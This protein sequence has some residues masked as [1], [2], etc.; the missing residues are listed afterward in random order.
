MRKLVS[1]E[2]ALRAIEEA[3]PAQPVGVVELSLEEALWRVAAEDVVA[4]MDVPG[5]RRALMD[6]YAVRAEDTFGAELEGPVRLRLVGSVRMGEPAEVRIGPGECVEVATGAMM[7]E[8]AD[9]VV[10]VEATV[11]EGD[12]VLVFEP[13]AP[14]QNVMAVGADVRAGDVVLRAGELLTPAKLGVLSA[15]GLRSVRVFKRPRVAVISTGDEL[16]EPGRPLEP[17]KIYDINW[18][19]LTAAIRVAGGEPIFMGRAGDELDELTEL[20]SR[21]LE[22]ADM[23]VASGASSVGSA[24]IMRDAL[25]AVGARVIVDGIRCKPGKP[26]IVALRGRKPLFCLPGH[27]TSAL[28][29]FMVFAEPVLAKMA[30]LKGVR[31]PVAKAI[32]VSRVLPDTGRHNFVPVA[33]ERSPDGHLLAKPIAKGSGAITSLSSAHGLVEAPEGT[34]LLPEGSEVEVRLFW[35]AWPIGRSDVELW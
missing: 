3:V 28:T 8:G 1:L 17:G 22:G 10:R 14:G 32:L 2:E 11:R 25:R 31:R 18:A 23:V 6:G 4:P 19:T 29:T 5:F 7:P 30:G 20:L 26:T 35:P 9:A 16:V 33:L 34:E 12:E 13:V 15:L 27:P 21:A 24:D